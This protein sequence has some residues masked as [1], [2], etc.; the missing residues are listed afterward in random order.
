MFYP[1][2]SVVINKCKKR[3]DF[4]VSTAALTCL[5]QIPYDPAQFGSVLFGM[6][7]S[8]IPVSIIGTRY[9]MDVQPFWKPDQYST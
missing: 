1:I 6:L 8:T 3:Y 2:L 7:G 5:F 9:A 4:M